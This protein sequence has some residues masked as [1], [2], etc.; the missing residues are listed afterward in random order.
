M[1]YESQIPDN[2]REA[3]FALQ[4]GV[5][6]DDKTIAL[7]FGESSTMFVLNIKA[8]KIFHA[9]IGEAISQLETE[10]NA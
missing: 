7:R 6:V 10:R 5:N 8:A 2:H 4:I 1:S 3:D 9:A